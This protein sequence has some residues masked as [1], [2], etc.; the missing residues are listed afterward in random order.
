MLE[1]G[2][3]MMTSVVAET[4]DIVTEKSPIP[5]QNIRVDDL[6]IRYFLYRGKVIHRT[7]WCR[8]HAYW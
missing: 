4:I 1:V 5:L 8:F 7:C 6:V 3:L 2:E